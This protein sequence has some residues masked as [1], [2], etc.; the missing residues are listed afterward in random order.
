MFRVL[1]LLGSLFCRCFCSRKDLL[2]E[3]LAL[4]QKLSVFKRRQRRPKLAAIDKLFWIGMNR[5]WSEWKN[6]LLMITPETVVRWHRGGF[7]LCWRWRSRH[8][9]GRGRKQ[10]HEQANARIYFSNGG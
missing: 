10:A 5:I 9:G 1:R 7:R 4:R 6:S 8:D 3:N 2:L